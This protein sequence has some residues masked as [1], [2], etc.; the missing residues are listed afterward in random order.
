M[1]ELGDVKRKTKLKNEGSRRLLLNVEE[2]VREGKERVKAGISNLVG[3]FT[4]LS[5]REREP[6]QYMPRAC[7]VMSNSGRN[8]KIKF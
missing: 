8:L 7:H 2:V 5:V 6:A 4:T 3:S 1:E